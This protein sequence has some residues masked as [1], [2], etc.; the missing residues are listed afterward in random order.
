MYSVVNGY[1]CSCS[2]DV[3]K[4]K[5]GVDPHQQTDGLQNAKKPDATKNGAVEPDSPAVV[6]GG[7]LA[8]VTPALAVQPS[9]ASGPQP[10]PQG[11]NILV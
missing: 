9:A 7:S 2:C 6:F 11:L 3:A 10:V 8:A 1:L 5:R 4:A